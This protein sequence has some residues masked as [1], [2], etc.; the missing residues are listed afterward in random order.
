MVQTTSILS[1][2]ILFLVVVCIF[3]ILLLTILN[4]LKQMSFFK[5]KTAVIVAA[6]VSLLGIIGLHQYFFV[7]TG[8]GGI[9]DKSENSGTGLNIILLPYAALVLAIL[10]LIF[11][12][13]V[14]TLFRDDRLKKH[15]AQIERRIKKSSLSEESNEEAHIRK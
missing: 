14:I 10:L 4:V 11:L 12:F 8:I 6:C 2:P 13:F 7:T 1:E 3:V 15:F 5:G 9:S